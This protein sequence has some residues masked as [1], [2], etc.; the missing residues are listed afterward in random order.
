MSH[1]QIN[2]SPDLNRL[3][4]EGYEIRIKDG[5]IFANHI[6]YLTPN[7]ELG[8]GVLACPIALAGDVALQ[9]P[10]HTAY[11]CGEHPCDVQ[12]QLM[13]GLVHSS[14][15]QPLPDGSRTN[16][17][18]SAKPKGGLYANYY[19]KLTT[20]IR[21]I[22]SHA[23][24]VYPYATA[25]THVSLTYDESAVFIYDDTNT[26]K[27]N[28]YPVSRKLEGLKIAIIGVGGTGSYILDLVAKTSVAEIHI[29]D[30][31]EMLSH[32]AFRS[33]GAPSI[34]T[35]RMRMK[36][37]DYFAGIYQN[38]R[39]KIHTHEYRVTEDNAHELLQYDFIFVS[40]DNGSSR[41]N[42]VNFLVNHNKSFIDVG[43]GVKQV[44]GS[45]IGQIRTTL[46]QAGDYDHLQRYVPYADRD[47]NE[48]T[49]NIQ[50]SELNSLNATL[51]VIK[52]KQTCGF[53]KDAY[54]SHNTNYVIYTGGL[55]HAYKEE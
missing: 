48:Y 22:S 25:Q 7:R 28:I 3:S 23:K 6:P 46:G 27:A 37:V 34:D 9:P 14:M 40:V 32:N 45:L 8:Y 36:K 29:Y 26:S 13:Q 43:I 20:Y 10:D 41:R 35:L 42:I 33:P 31:D 2:L 18:L 5:Y 1:Q 49:S 16:F 4:L 11:F 44:D 15:D 47:D 17:Y 53:Y 12:G 38:I 19:D 55:S 50:I 39:K 30:N 54:G 24:E 52:W 51:A 21:I